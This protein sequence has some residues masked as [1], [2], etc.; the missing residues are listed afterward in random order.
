M[1]EWDFIKCHKFR[2]SEKAQKKLKNLQLCFDVT[3]QFIKN[4]GVFSNFVAFSQYLNFS[5]I[6]MV[7]DKI[8][9]YAF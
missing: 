4:V 7:I 3:K 1:A 9:D 2:Y 5:I 6:F 8:N